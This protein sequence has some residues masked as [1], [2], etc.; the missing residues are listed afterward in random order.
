[1]KNLILTLWLIL[2]V[3]A[4]AA[5]GSVVF[6]QVTADDI[7]P[8]VGHC[9]DNGTNLRRTDI[10]PD[11]QILPFTVHLS[12]FPSKSSFCRPCS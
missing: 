4:V 10:E 1:M 2:I 5:G 7:E 12:P 3:V 6:A 8:V 11:D 9:P